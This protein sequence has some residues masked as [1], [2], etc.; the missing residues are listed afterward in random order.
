MSA[1]SW[2]PHD[3]GAVHGSAPSRLIFSSTRWGGAARAGRGG[4]RTRQRRIAK[5]RRLRGNEWWGGPRGQSIRQGP[6]VTERHWPVDWLQAILPSPSMQRPMAFKQ[7]T[8]ALGSGLE[9]G[10]S[11]RPCGFKE[12]SRAA[13]LLAWTGLRRSVSFGASGTLHGKRNR[14]LAMERPTAR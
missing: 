5:C 14:S 9:P 8:R 6:R 12:P 7:I 13:A 2:L 1:N 11:G 4:R 3:L 10:S